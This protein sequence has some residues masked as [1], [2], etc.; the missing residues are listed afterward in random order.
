MYLN[1]ET[2]AVIADIKG[3]IN[4]I[5]VFICILIY[6]NHIWKQ[7]LRL[8]LDPILFLLYV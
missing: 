3:K 6:T 5:A 1:V 2:V 7:T 8:H 4:V